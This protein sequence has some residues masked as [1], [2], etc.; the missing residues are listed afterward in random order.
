MAVP[1]KGS[2]PQNG[3]ADFY[4]IFNIAGTIRYQYNFPTNLCKIPALITP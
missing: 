1:I 2:Q 4:K 3:P